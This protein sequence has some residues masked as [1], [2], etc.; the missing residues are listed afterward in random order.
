MLKIGISHYHNAEKSLFL[1]P[2]CKK[3]KPFIYE[4]QKKKNF[5]IVITLMLFFII[6]V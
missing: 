1:L 4:M 2:L 3:I 5:F 6:I